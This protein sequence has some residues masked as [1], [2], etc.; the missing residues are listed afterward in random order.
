M[1]NDV[2]YTRIEEIYTKFLSGFLAAANR[3]N[4]RK[5]WSGEIFQHTVAKRNECGIEVK[6]CGGR[7]SNL[8]R[9]YVEVLAL[10]SLKTV[11]NWL[12]EDE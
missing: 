8:Y 7:A 11:I 4:R 12:S 5:L 2:S 3:M 6:H 1:T 10:F 9:K